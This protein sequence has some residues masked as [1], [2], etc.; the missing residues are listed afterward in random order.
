MGYIFCPNNGLIG[1]TM[2]K[3][4]AIRMVVP[5]INLMSVSIHIKVGAY[6]VLTLQLQSEWSQHFRMEKKIILGNLCMQE[7]DSFN[8]NCYFGQ[9]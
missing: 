1:L 6:E 3:K 2:E 8:R 9:N 7:I 5:S 4:E